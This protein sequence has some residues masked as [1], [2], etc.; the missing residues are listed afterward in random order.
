MSPTDEACLSLL[1]SALFG[2]L[3]FLRTRYPKAS[4]GKETMVL[5][6]ATIVFFSICNLF[7]GSHQVP[8][9]A[10]QELHQT[11]ADLVKH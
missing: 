5:A 10:G 8:V 9:R 6:G 7:L 1:L 4:K 11:Q 2:L 3:L